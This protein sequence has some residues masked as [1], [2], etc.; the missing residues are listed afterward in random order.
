MVIFTL[1]RVRLAG[2][3]TGLLLL[4]TLTTFAQ[5]PPGNALAFDGTGEYVTGT[6]SL[7]PQNNSPV[8]WKPGY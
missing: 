3:L 8:P 7:L 5:V 2:L 4:N 6:N 1:L